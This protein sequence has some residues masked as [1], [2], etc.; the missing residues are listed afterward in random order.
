MNRLL[1]TDAYHLT[2]G[3]LIGE[4]E[5][6]QPETHV[7]YARAGGPLVVPDLSAVL[8]D[9]LAWRVTREDIDHAQRFWTSQGILFSI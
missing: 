4:A 5:A 3:Y 9:F 6:M 7:L 8:K 1:T 2:M